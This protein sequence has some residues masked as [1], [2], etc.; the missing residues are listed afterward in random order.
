MHLTT[1]FLEAVA[2]AEDPSSEPLTFMWPMPGSPGRQIRTFPSFSDWQA[3]VLDLGL[4]RTV[5]T[6]VATKFERG[7]KLLLLAWVDFD[8]FTAGELIA[9]TALEL[10]LK[11]L[12]LGK[13]RD[14]RRAVIA[15]RAQAEQRS[16]T[17]KE[18]SWIEQVSFADL[19]K[20]MVE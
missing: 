13:E 11:D 3:F 19:L 20:Y 2:Q 8:L 18:K 17:K 14:R 7:Q 10:A 9:L 16:V 4:R 6:V 5:P 1:R 15:Q 12:Y